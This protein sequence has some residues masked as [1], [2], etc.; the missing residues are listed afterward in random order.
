MHGL[1]LPIMT[2][3][4]IG[5]GLAAIGLSGTLCLYTGLLLTLHH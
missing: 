3:K 2:G 5:A 4:Y 1:H